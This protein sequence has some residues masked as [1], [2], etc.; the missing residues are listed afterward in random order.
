MELIQI[1]S[2]QI[3]YTSP[4]YQHLPGICALVLLDGKHPRYDSNGRIMIIPRDQIP[5]LVERARAQ[6]RRANAEYQKKN[7]TTQV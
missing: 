5:G 4:N 1:D 7:S 3:I 2:L 6:S